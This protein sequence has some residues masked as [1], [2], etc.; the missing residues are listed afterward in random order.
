MLENKKILVTG[1]AG[2]IGSHL[3][4][5]LVKKNNEVH[6]LDNL[7]R[8]NKID[9][10]I[11]KNINFINGDVRNFDTII[12]I[13]KNIDVIF[14]LAA[15]LGVDD[16]AKNPIETME[17]ETIG[18]Q[19]LVKA[20]IKHSINKI[21]YTS[22]SGVYGK[23]EIN[24]A[25]NEDYQ[26]APSSSYAI[27][28]RFNEIYLKSITAK[29]NIDTFSLRYFNVYGLRQ[30]NRMVI[31]RFFEQA[32]KNEPI[33]VYG[34]GKQT[35]D[36]TFID[37]TIKAT[38]SIA[39]QCKKNETFNI[40]RGVDTSMNELAQ[41]IVNIT[42]SKSEIL[43]IEAPFLRYDFDVEKRWGDSSKLYKFTNF[44]PKIDL[45]DGLNNIYSN[46]NL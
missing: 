36:F 22:T 19:N 14:H 9:K 37:D 10:R 32:I 44:R 46:I 38:I 1:G 43:H 27:A 35:R 41:I 40:A 8:G 21:I 17:V 39:E 16:V 7:L 4:D 18:T 42:N 34:D 31:P 6:V 20:S 2:F 24:D 23:N 33:K 30:D 15:Y 5:G 12:K 26:V 11:R 13:T 29:Y 25:V 45:I 28:K 3:V